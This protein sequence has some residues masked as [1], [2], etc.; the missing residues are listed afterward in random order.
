MMDAIDDILP[1]AA[2]IA[3]SPLPVIAVVLI[4]GSPQA[5]LAGPAYLAGW[6]LGLTA[7]AIA[8]AIL[9]H[10]VGDIGPTGALI[11][12]WLRLALGA[13]LLWAAASKW[14]SRPDGTAEPAVPKWLEAFRQITPLAAL[15]WGA[16]L[17]VLNPKHI[18]L[19]LAA[20]ASLAYVPLLASENLLT[21]VLF[22]ALSSLT[23]A[24]IV[25]AH[26]IAGKRAAPFI[27]SVEQFLLR[28]HD[29]IIIVVLTIIGMAVLGE[30][31]SGLLG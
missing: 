2:A 29:V 28:H 1:I 19:V 13:L 10:L 8:S 9:V 24:A 21:T 4:A 11:L 17:A 25:V 26:A 7:L 16:I 12:D 15:R 23:I 27:Q 31:L 6:V 3:L 14:R 5:R 20:M 18:G 22:I 30:G